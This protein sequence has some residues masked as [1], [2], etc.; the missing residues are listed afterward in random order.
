MLEDRIP[1]GNYYSQKVIGSRVLG[2]EPETSIYKWLA[3]RS[4]DFHQ[5]WKL[6]PIDIQVHRNWGSVF[7][8]PQ[9]TIIDQTPGKHLS[10]GMVPWYRYRVTWNRPPLVRDDVQTNLGGGFKYFLF[11]PLPGEMIQF[12]QYASKGLK[13]PTSNSGAGFWK[14]VWWSRAQLEVLTWSVSKRTDFWRGRDRADGAVDD[15]LPFLDDV[16]I[17]I[18]IYI[19]IIYVP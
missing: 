3:I 19:H 17:Y 18:Y 1:F 4:D 13:P 16:G 10:F 8:G 9:K 6:I 7:L 15:D 12:D 11:S 5:I 14:V 2:L